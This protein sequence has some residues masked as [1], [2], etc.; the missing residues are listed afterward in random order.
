MYQIRLKDANARIKLTID[1][2]E[3]E[4]HSDCKFDYLHFYDGADEFAKSMGKYCL[5]RSTNSTIVSSSNVMLI[6][7][8]TDKSF[9]GNGFILSYTKFCGYTFTEKSGVVKSN[10]YPKLAAGETLCVFEIRVPDNNLIK[11]EFQDL[12][13]EHSNNCTTDSL[14]IYETI[15]IE[16]AKYCGNALPDIYISDFNNL[17]MIL[18]IK[19]T[20]RHRGFKLSYSSIEVG[21]GGLLAGS[22]G[23]FSSP[24]ASSGQ[25]YKANIKCNWIIRAPLNQVIKLTF[26]TFSIEK[27]STCK[28]DYV[29]VL[30]SRF[31]EIGKFC[32]NLHP[33]LIQSMD[34][35]LIVQFVSDKTNQLEGF[36]ASFVFTNASQTCG[37]H[38]A[39]DSGVIT[40]PGFY[41]EKRYPQ[42]LNCIW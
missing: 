24:I 39:Q 38:L 8:R 17:I 10:G 5:S 19:Y 11:L 27:H 32:G 35:E 37:S 31:N 14:S 21:C 28:F 40:S 7:F 13:I 9:R 36:S 26:N 18:K 33:P 20:L 6:K 41:T 34:N 23:F 1:Y 29:R 16:K 30:D 2:L 42:N 22:P 12:D 15:Q 25:S 3:L 4:E